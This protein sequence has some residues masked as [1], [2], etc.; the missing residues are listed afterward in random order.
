MFLEDV[1]LNSF[2]FVLG[3]WAEDL[4]FEIFIVFLSVLISLALELQ[5]RIVV[6]RIAST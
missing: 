5:E 6:E 2:Y 3:D 4:F 1:V